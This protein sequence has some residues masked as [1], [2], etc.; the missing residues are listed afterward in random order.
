MHGEMHSAVYNVCSNRSPDQVAICTDST[1]YL[2]GIEVI[3]PKT[4]ATPSRSSSFGGV[5]FICTKTKQSAL[6]T[7][8]AWSRSSG[9]RHSA[10]YLPDVLVISPSG[11]CSTDAARG[12]M[13]RCKALLT[14]PEDK[15]VSSH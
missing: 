11:T 6:E 5:L 1:V 7:S 9:C 3:G 10:L 4:R 13:K 8:A 2:Y 12:G 14:Q 15:Q